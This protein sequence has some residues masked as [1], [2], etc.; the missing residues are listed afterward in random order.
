MKQ[1]YKNNNDYCVG[2]TCR[3]VPPVFYG[4]GLIRFKHSF[5]LTVDLIRGIPALLVHVIKIRE[6]EAVRAITFV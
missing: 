2:G 4:I 3:C 5:V 1:T 6:T